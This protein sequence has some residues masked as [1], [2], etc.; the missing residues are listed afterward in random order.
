M[1]HIRCK[2]QHFTSAQGV[3]SILHAQIGQ[4][5]NIQHGYISVTLQLYLSHYNCFC[6]DYN[7]IT[8]RPLP[9]EAESSHVALTGQ[10]G[11]RHWR[12]VSWHTCP[13]AHVTPSQAESLH[14]HVAHPCGSSRKPYIHILGQDIFGHLCRSKIFKNFIIK[15]TKM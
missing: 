10:G 14:W 6:V 12:G 1:N 5:R 2:S 7:L 13:S 11:T 8:G 9:T 4:R 3:V 15:D